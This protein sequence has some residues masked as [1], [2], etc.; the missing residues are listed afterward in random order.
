M[1]TI[2][3]CSG[4][5]E[6]KI[7]DSFFVNEKTF[8]NKLFFFFNKK[9]PLSRSKVIPHSELATTHYARQLT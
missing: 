8:S 5:L 4:E 1:K 7:E 6:K 2:K 3:R 9:G